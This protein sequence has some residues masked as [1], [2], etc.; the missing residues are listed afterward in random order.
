MQTD[1]DDVEE[2]IWTGDELRKVFRANEARFASEPNPRPSL[3]HHLDDPMTRTQQAAIP[4]SR[5][6]D[7]RTELLW[8]KFCHPQ[9]GGYFVSRGYFD[10]DEGTWIARL[11]A[12][13]EENQCGP[14]TPFC[15]SLIVAG[16]P[17]TEWI[18]T[19]ITGRRRA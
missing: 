13:G 6:E 16:Q 8:V 18:G 19:I 10:H 2:Q 7:S 5:P 1:L 15:W 12:E 17:P 14:V 11:R 4:R 3:W 9:R